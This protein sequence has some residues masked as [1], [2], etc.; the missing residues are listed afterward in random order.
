[1][2]NDSKYL[3]VAKQR[4]FIKNIDREKDDESDYENDIN[5]K[6]KRRTSIRLKRTSNKKNDISAEDKDMCS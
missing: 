3:D 4:S 5:A 2:N 1:M 6:N